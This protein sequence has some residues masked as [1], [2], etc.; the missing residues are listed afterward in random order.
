MRLLPIAGLLLGAAALAPAADAPAPRCTDES[1]RQFD[2][3]IGHWD[4]RGPQGQPLGENRITAAPDGCSLYEAWQ[5][6]GGVVGHS[7]NRYDAATGRWRQR[8]ID[9][10]GGEL[11]L[12]GGRQGA[13]M[14]LEGVDGEGAARKRQRITWSP[15]PDGSLRQLWE[16]SDDDGRRWQ[17]AFDGRYVRRRP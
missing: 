5:G 12:S 14:V 10:Q 17:T 4:V 3:W 16:T 2:F 1:H 13:A 8:W 6:R 11:D 15:Q 9:N 7:L